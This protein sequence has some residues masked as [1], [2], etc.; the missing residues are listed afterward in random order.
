MIE[1][2]VAAIRDLA[3][4]VERQTAPGLEAAS[5]RLTETRGIEHSNFT[6]VVPSLAV[7]YVAAVEFLEEELRTK[8]EHL[9][10]M[11]SRLN[12]TADNWEAADKASTIMIA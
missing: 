4:A 3:E 5:A 7:A 11:R 6:V 8:R 12:R 2:D 10:E 9:T 1:V